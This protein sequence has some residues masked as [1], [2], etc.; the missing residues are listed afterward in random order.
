MHAISAL[1]RPGDSIAY[2]AGRTTITL[3]YVR[4]GAYTVTVYQ[5]TYRVEDQCGSYTTEPIA[6]SVAHLYAELA[7]AEADAEGSA[8]P[9]A[10]LPAVALQGSHRQVRPTMAGAQLADVTDPQH[11][12]L[13]TAVA[14]GRVTRGGGTYQESVATLRALARKG[15]VRLHMRP[16]RR[17]DIDH[18]TLTAAGERELARLDAEATRR[19]QRN[20]QLATLAA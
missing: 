13:A 3:Q 11:R 19:E 8:A 14:F 20:D 17:Y 6:R 18:A 4:D 7:K 12:A 16:G 5:G 15:L 2:T 1:S 10:S 9:V